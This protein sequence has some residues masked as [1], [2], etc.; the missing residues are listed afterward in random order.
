MSEPL[1]RQALK[2]SWRLTWNHKVLWVLGLL[3]VFCG[4]MGLVE[5]LTKMGLATNNFANYPNW[6]MVPGVIKNIPLIVRWLA[7]P[8]EMNIWLICLLLIFLGIGL[9]LVFAAVVAQGGLI[10]VAA[11][12]SKRGNFPSVGRAWNR[13]VKCFWPLLLLNIIKKL[14]LTA[15]ILA[16]GYA[17]V[18]VLLGITAGGVILFFVLFVLASGIGMAMAFLLIY[19]AAYVVVEDY[20]FIR[21][22]EAAWQLFIK[23]WL[24]SV[25]VGLIILALNVVVAMLTVLGFFVFFLPTLLTWFIAV[26]TVNSALWWVGL[27][28][29]LFFSTLFIIFLGSVFTV[30]TTSVW[31]YLFVKMHHEGVVSRII[32][33]LRK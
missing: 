1:Y 31:T 23:H 3:A 21:A 4:Q 14:V 26:L 8:L 19:A 29:G 30:Y 25:E 12:F 17:A 27:L 28:V 7:L 11:D 22:A 9:F 18:N 5:I 16:V 15:L 6:L 33:W 2:N 13:G 10:K 24:V 20:T 32:Q